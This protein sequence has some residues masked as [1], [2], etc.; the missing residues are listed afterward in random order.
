MEFGCCVTPEQVP[1]LAAASG[2]YAEFNVAG[3]VMGGDEAAFADL[4]ARVAASP[5][6]PLAYSVFLP[7]DR[8]VVGPAVD[9]GALEEYARTAFGRI[10]RLSGDAPVIV[11]FGSGRSRTI[12]DGFPRARALDQLADLLGWV[13]PL[14]AEYGV[15]IAVEHLRQ[16]ESNVFNT[17]RE[18]GTF[19]R[20]RDL[21]G[22]RLLADIY[23][24]MEED[25]PLDTIDD[26]ADLI[27][28]A[29]AADSGRRHPGTGTYPL[30]DFFT[31]LHRNGYTGRCSIECRWTDFPSEIGPALAALR[32]AESS[33]VS[34]Q[35]SEE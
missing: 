20:E 1:A 12:P 13:G 33:V 11:V 5:L 19:L 27:A 30:A 25:E 31:R 8:A 14:A 17:L 22:I 26:F 34:R 15:T 24:L 18:C 35:S 3:T 29:H 10:R 32:V 23:H 4:L 21:P 2:D 9:R 7:G 28:H 16:A 6:K